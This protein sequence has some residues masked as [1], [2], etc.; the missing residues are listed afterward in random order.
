MP[1][2]EP[3]KVNLIMADTDSI[4][5]SVNTRNFFEK[6][7]RLPLFDFSNFKKE[8]SLYSNPNQ[9]ALPFSR[10]EIPKTL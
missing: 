2:F 10:M 8:S 7:K 3:D 6:Y 4:I 1:T 9:K 5:F